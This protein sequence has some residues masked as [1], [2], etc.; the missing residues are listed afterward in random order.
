MEHTAFEAAREALV[1]ARRE[2][3]AIGVWPAHWKPA[4]VDEACRLQA[5]VA[6]SLGTIGGWKI[7]AV[8][9]AQR[10]ALG[11]PRPLGAP[12][13]APWL[14]D[15]RDARDAAATAPMDASIAQFRVRD[16]IVPKLECEFAFELAHDLP[17]R[18]GQPYTRGEVEAATGAMRLA[19][20]IVDSRLPHGSGALAELA[21]GFNN[22]ALVCGPAVAQWQSLAFGQ[23]GIRLHASRG[24]ESS[25]SEL[26]LGSGAAILDGDPFGTVVMLANVPSEP[27][28][29]LRAGQI[30]T[31]GS[32]TGAPALP[33]PGFYRAEFAGLGSV[34]VRFV[35]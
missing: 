8:T 24:G 6:A 19:I 7:A 29:G 15:A 11:V 28:I 22:G 17:P 21:D 33:G 35:A 1:T 26:A 16:F 30:V 23:I 12:V 20:E 31:T 34:S 25:S 13:L 3:R 14:R 4:D 10:A 27:G 9:E 5:A 18:P 2:A 32:C